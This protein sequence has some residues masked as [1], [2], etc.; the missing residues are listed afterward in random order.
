M[1]DPAVPDPVVT[2]QDMTAG[3]EFEEL[4][5][6]VLRVLTAGEPDVTVERDVKLLGADG[7]RQID[8]VIRS[9]VGPFPLTTIVE[10]KDYGR[11]VDV[12]RRLALRHGG[13]ERP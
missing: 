1:T 12:T 3:G 10:C 7:P 4:I 5:E 8:V 9:A 2:L 6:H 13:R 11:K